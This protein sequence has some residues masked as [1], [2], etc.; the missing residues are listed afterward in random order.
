MRY[1]REPNKAVREKNDDSLD[2][3]EHFVNCVAVFYN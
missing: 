2:V 1:K 3:I